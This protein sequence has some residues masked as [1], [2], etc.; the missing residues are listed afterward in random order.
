[1]TLNIQ[2]QEALQALV[3]YVLENERNHF[4]EYLE[5]GGNPDDH[6]YSKAIILNELKQEIV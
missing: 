1:M 5:D 3:D 6:I 2:Q 4:T